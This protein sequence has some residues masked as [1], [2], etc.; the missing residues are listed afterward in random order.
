[1]S[2]SAELAR[3]EK[4]QKFQRHN[5][6]RQGMNPRI[7]GQSAL[8]V[9]GAQERCVALYYAGLGPSLKKSVL[10]TLLRSCRVPSLGRLVEIDMFITKLCCYS[11]GS[12]QA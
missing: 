8:L 1:M 10:L 12:S 7:L 6:H 2:L 4:H 5:Y 3:E 9:A 11:R